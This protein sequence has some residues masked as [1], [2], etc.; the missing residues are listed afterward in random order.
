MRMKR[1]AVESAIGT[2]E[3]CLSRW[4]SCRDSVETTNMALP[5][6][7]MGIAAQFGLV[8]TLVS[9]G[10]SLAGVIYSLYANIS[11]PP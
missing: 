1:R 9:S 3:E 4:E 10:V 5:V 8:S 2:L 7:V 11:T 6:T